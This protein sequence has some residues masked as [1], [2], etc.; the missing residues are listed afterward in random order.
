[1]D[2]YG[3]MVTLL[4]C[5]FVLMYSMST[6]SEEK[7]RAIVTSFNPF[8][9]ETPTDPEGY[10][11]PV[12]DPSDQQGG[13]PSIPDVAAQREIDELIDDLFY[14]LQA[15]SQEDGMQNTI[16]VTMDGGKVY[17]MF[18]D[19]VFF[20]GDSYELKA[21][22][23]EI[24]SQVCA[25]LDDAEPAI[26][27]IRIQ[28]H[29]AQGSAHT[30]NEPRFDRFLASNRATEVLLYIQLNSS[31][32]PARLA[33]EGRGQWWPITSNETGESRAFNRR[34][35]MIISGRNLQEEELGNAISKYIVGDT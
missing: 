6:I 23:R 32:H 35:E 13:E 26:E 25:V 29:T 2:T 21:Q 12:A 24:L 3:D 14:A 30:L 27:E 19:T 22:A 17:V 20:D 31:I 28:G 5:F 33:S 18:N 10:D 1:M 8:A 9:Q 34:V 4:L 16:S 11:G 15:L 7:W